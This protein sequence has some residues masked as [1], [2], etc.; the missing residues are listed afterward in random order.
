[1]SQPLIEEGRFRFG[2]LSAESFDLLDTGEQVTLTIRARVKKVIK[3]EQANEGDRHVM[4]LGVEK[5]LRGVDKT[6]N[7]EEQPEPS[8]FDSE[9]ADEPNEPEDEGEPD[10]EESNGEGASV[11]SIGTGFTGGPTF[12]A[13]GDE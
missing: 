9:P 6:I 10:P 1:M 2:G 3:E 12:S 13:G 7:D 4:V 5:V 8:L 11:S